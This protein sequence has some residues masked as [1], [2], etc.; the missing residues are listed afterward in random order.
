MT[1]PFERALKVYDTLDSL[2]KIVGESKVFEG[3]KTDAFDASG[4]SRAYYTEV[5]DS[6]VES[7]SLVERQ[8][9]GGSRG[10]S[11]IEILSR[12]TR[13]SFVQA[14]KRRHLTTTDSRAKILEQRVEDLNRRLPTIDLN[15]YI[16]A[17]EARIRGIEA[18]LNVLEGGNKL[19]A[20]Q[21]KP[22]PTTAGTTTG[23]NTDE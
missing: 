19:H 2:A 12:P 5:F 22:A 16:V 18:R 4:V 13:E 17:Q 14:G 10:Q 8:R 6:L 3:R 21:E 15:S 20:S 7:G 23:G 1:D 11:K 9:G